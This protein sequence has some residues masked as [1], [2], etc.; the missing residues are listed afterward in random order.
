[1]VDGLFQDWFELFNPTATNVDI[2]G[3]FLS[4]DAPGPK[5]FRIPDGTMI[6]ADGYLVFTETEFNAAPGSLTS[7]SLSSAGD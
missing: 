6:A 3:W 1:M 2:G 4:D 7:F 5:K